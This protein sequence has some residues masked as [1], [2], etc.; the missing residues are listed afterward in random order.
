MSPILAIEEKVFILHIYGGNFEDFWNVYIKQK[1]LLRHFS[2]FWA[3]HLHKYLQDIVYRLKKMVFIPHIG[4]DIFEGLK[5]SQFL[6]FFNRNSILLTTKL[7]P[8]A[9]P[10]AFSLWFPAFFI[11]SLGQYNILLTKSK[12]FGVKKYYSYD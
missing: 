8:K 3:K 2:I 10:R 4:K 11:S 5:K 6:K 7:M 1:T 9:K 12:R